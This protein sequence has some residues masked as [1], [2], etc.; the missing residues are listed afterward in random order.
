MA[1]AVTLEYD[2]ARGRIR[3]EGEDFAGTVAGAR[4][5]WRRVAGGGQWFPV[6]GGVVPVVSG[7]MARPVDDYEFPAGEDIEYLVEGLDAGGAVVESA[8]V[9]R[10]AVGDRVWLKIVA[11]PA[12]NRPVTLAGWSPIKRQSRSATYDVGGRSDPVVV[13]D[14]H[15]SRIVTIT[16]VT[17]THEETDALDDALDQGQPIFLQVPKGV[18]LPTL[19]ASVG[20]YEHVPLSTRSVRSRWTIPL[21][22]VAPPPPS[23]YGT[24]ETWATVLDEYDTWADLLAAE[25][26]WREVA[27]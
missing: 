24:F 5:S 19:Y 25:A 23:V 6:R 8:Q 10:T 16:L 20:D 11:A 1:L 27:A 7:L 4:V 2:D 18:G 12:S 17:H 26:T 22:E 9:T 13:S 21:V 15:S 3:V 14:V